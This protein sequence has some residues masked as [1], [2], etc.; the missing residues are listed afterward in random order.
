VA[1]YRPNLLRR[2]QIL[3]VRHS[4]K[5]R[6]VSREAFEQSLLDRAKTLNGGRRI[7]E[8]PTAYLRHHVP[9]PLGGQRPIRVAL[10]TPNDSVFSL[11]RI[12][13]N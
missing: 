6:Q 10:P 5:P 8:A 3:Q 13:L 4:R 9:F 7:S 2:L 11:Q 12:E 1:P